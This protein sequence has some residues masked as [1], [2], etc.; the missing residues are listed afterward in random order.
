MCRLQ[1]AVSREREHGMLECKARERRRLPCLVGRGA[2][3]T[4]RL[5][6]W[7]AG[8]RAG[9]GSAAALQRARARRILEP[10]ALSQ[11]AA[12]S[13]QTDAR[14]FS[15]C[16]YSTLSV[17]ACS[18]LLCSPL[19]SSARPVVAC[20]R[21]PTSPTPTPMQRCQC[22]VPCPDIESSWCRR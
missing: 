14:C 5:A 2:A 15:P 18:A 7:Q 17:V 19:L 6:G 4:G 12:S 11:H 13:Q 10:E 20:R 1:R 22:R 3:S 9:R 8:R 21:H 16:Q